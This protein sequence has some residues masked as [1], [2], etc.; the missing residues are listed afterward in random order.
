MRGKMQIKNKVILSLSAPIVIIFL[1]LFLNSCSPSDA[2]EISAFAP[3]VPPLS[4][5]S[6]D[7]NVY[8]DCKTIEDKVVRYSCYK[9]ISLYA[10]QHGATVEQLLQF[11]KESKGNHLIQH[12]IG[13][14]AIISSDYNLSEGGELCT[15]LKC[16]FGYSHGIAIGWGE[17]APQGK[18]EIVD[19]LSGYCITGDICKH[20]L[21]H[22]YGTLYENLEENIALCDR[23]AYNANFSNCA[24]GSIHQYF[25]NNNPEVKDFFELCSKFNDGRRKEICYTYGS[26]L[27]PRYLSSEMDTKG[28]FKLC[29]EINKEVPLGWNRCYEGINYVLTIKKKRRNEEPTIEMCRDLDDTFKELCIDDLLSPES[30]WI[31][32]GC[33][34]DKT[35]GCGVPT[36]SNDIEI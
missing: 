17:Y 20:H 21:G 2:P 4:N 3:I 8:L 34:V 13:T 35:L 22:F 16:M 10:M 19:F 25:Q 7:K 9:D 31:T 1:S 18:S 28:S 14:A 26:F 11:A 33:T 15:G 36:G 27:F 32:S 12:S 5:F 24:S 29:E 23:I 30:V 6:T